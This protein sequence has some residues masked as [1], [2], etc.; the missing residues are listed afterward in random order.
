MATYTWQGKTREGEVKRG[1]LV[2]DNMA[3]ARLQLRKMGIIPGRI[4]EKKETAQRRFALRKK[5]PRKL[6]VVFTRQ[7][8][9]MINAGLPLVSSRKIRLF[10]MSSPG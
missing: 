7:F 1:E 9:T 8:A 4:Q 6:V 10:P 5:I 2:A 3:V